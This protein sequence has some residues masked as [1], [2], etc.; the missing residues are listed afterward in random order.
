MITT[1][2]LATYIYLAG[3]GICSTA[4]G[5]HNGLAGGLGFLGGGIVILS[6]VVFMRH[7]TKSD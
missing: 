5:L 6:F 1:L 7:V 2:R 3:L 4:I